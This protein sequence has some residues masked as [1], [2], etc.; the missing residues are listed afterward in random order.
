[1]DTVLVTG[2]A[3]FIGSHLVEALVAKGK[4]V[5][6]L[7][8]LSS[9]SKKNLKACKNV[10]LVVG[11]ITNWKLLQE[12]FESY[13]FS[14]VFHL[15]AIPSVPK[16]VE[17]PIETHNVNFD[18]TLFLLEVSKK[19]NVKKFI[20]A[21][22]AAVYGDNE[23]LPKK[24]DMAVNPTTPYGVDKFASERYVV[25]AYRLY[26]LN[27]TALR[28][29]NVYGERQNPSSPYSGV[30]SIFVDRVLSFQRGKKTTIE[31]F[32]D[33]NQ[34]RDFIYVK[35]VVKSILLVSEREETAGEVY[36][37]G[38][39]KETSLLDLVETLKEISG[40]FPNVRF[41]PQRKGDI[42]RSVADISKLKSLGFKPEVSLKEGLKR[43]FLYELEE[44]Y[45]F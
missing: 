21:S 42:K 17:K 13:E 14:S 5:V 38:T 3:G 25:N 4:K 39:G 30:I 6:V 34:T 44:K 15:A 32:G 43:T 41:L 35:D 29:F 28:F 40:K 36:N 16:S 1:M 8:D 23:D 2:G 20:F 19:F 26:G 22:S 33:G 31:I 37:V 11:S 24:E 27:T 7:D 12:L 18:G 45:G 9:G 10:I